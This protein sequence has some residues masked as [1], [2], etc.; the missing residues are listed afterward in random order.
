MKLKRFSGQVRQSAQNYLNQHLII[1]AFLAKYF[2]VTL[3]S[4][5]NVLS[6]QKEHFSRFCKFLSGE[7]Q[8]IFW[9]SDGK[10]SK[11]FKSKLGHREL[12]RKMF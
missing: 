2:E 11:I 4:K 7:V 12:F 10:R 9:E 1:P 8:N 6:I 3:S 5:T